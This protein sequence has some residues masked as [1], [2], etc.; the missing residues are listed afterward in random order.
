MPAKTKTTII[1][2]FALLSALPALAV[3]PGGSI[4]LTI[5][6][7]RNSKGV[8]LVTVFNQ[9]DGFPSDSTKAFRTYIVEARSPEISINISQLPSAQY[10]IAI[11]HDENN[12]LALDTNLI[13][14]PVEGYAASGSNRRFS[15]PR[16]E[17]SRFEV[18]GKPVAIRVSMNYLF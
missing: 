7:I 3:E 4:N 16:F 17:S 1:I 10:A 2:L 11:V 14:A 18:A 9:P 13:G 12:N 6:S 15:A 5:T 8:I